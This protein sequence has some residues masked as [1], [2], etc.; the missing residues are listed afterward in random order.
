MFKKGDVINAI[1]PKEYGEWSCLMFTEDAKPVHGNPQKYMGKPVRF[2][3]LIK[4]SLSLAEICFAIPA[5]ISAIREN[6]W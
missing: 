3:R 6:T 2:V 4:M 5:D 1:P